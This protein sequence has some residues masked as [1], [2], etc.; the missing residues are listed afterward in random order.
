MRSLYLRSRNLS[1]IWKQIY[2]D[3]WNRAKTIIRFHKNKPTVHW[4]YGMGS[5]HGRYWTYSNE[6][7]L[8]NNY[9]Q[10]QFEGTE[11][12]K[13]FRLTL[14]HE[15]AH[16]VS[17]GHG[18]E[19]KQAMNRLGANRFA[20]IFLPTMSPAFGPAIRIKKE[21]PTINPIKLRYERVLNNLKTATTKQKRATTLMKKY[22]LKIRYFKNRYPEIL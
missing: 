12:E 11:L 1:G 7:G 14:R 18:K 8:N 22:Q 15:F 21:R 19:F 16:I 6:I 3:E 2:T 4:E 10:E 5:V 17:A 20:T 13:E 9:L